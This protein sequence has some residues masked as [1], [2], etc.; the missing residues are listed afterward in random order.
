[1]AGGPEYEQVEKPT[2]EFLENLGYSFIDQPQNEDAREGLYNVILR[3][4]LIEA[5]QRI[6]KV[7][8]E[9]AE[10]TYS[11]LLSVRDHQRW[12]DILR[13]DYSRNVPGKSTQKTIRLIDFLNTDNNVFTLTNQFYVQSE[14]SRIPDLVVFVNGIPLVVIEAKKPVPTK[15]KMGE[16]FD[17]IKQ[18][19]QDIPRLFYSNTFNI[20]CDSHNLLFGAT[21]A[22]S[23]YWSTWRDPWP[24]KDE[25]F[26]N[27]RERGLYA[28]LEPSRLLD[29]LAHFIVFEKEDHKVTKKICRYQQFR[30]VNK[31]VNRVM[32]GKHQR[33]LIWHT[34]GSGKSLTMVFAALKLKKHLTVEHE[35]LTSP[36]LLV[37]TDRKALDKQ[38]AR[39]FRACG[40]PNP[41]RCASV[42]ELRKKL[43]Q[44]TLGLTLLST[45]H[46]FEGS[47]KS[48]ANAKDWIVLVDE[49]HR[50]QEKDLG[51]YLQATLDGARFFG[52]TGTPVKKTDRNTYKHFGAPGEGYLDR[53]SI[54]DSIADG[55]TVP[56][57]YTSRKAEFEVDEAKLDVLFDNWFKSVDE[58]KREEL[59]RKG[60]TL[61]TIAKVPE[62]IDLIAYDIWTHYLEHVKPDGFKAQVVAIDREAVILYKRALDKYITA[63][64]IREGKTP[65]EA[66][67]LADKFSTPVYSGNQEDGKPSEDPWVDGIRQDLRDNF[68]DEDDTDDAINDF[69]H[70]EYPKFLIVCSK[71]LTGFD[72]PIE[73]V[74]YLDQPLK[75]HNLLQA[76]ART[77]RPC[78]EHKQYG[79]IVDYIGVT[80]HLEEAL[81]SYHKADVEHALED[82]SGLR[83]KLRD[84][85]REVMK[86]IEGLEREK[87]TE[88][89]YQALAQ[90]LGSEDVWYTYRRKARWFIKTYEALSPDPYVLNFQK[91]LKWIAGSLVW[92]TVQFEKKDGVVDL[93]SYSAKIREMLERHLHVTGLRTLCEL[94][95]L[96][97]PKFWKDFDPNKSETDLKTAAIRKSAELKK[98]LAEKVSLNPLRYGPFSERVMELIKRLEAGQTTIAL[99]LKEMEQVAKDLEAEN[100]AH[101]GSGLDARAYGLFKILETFWQELGVVADGPADYE[102]MDGPITR[103]TK[104]IDE[105]YNSP[106][107]AP[108]GWH[109]K[110]QL[111]KSL[112]QQVRVKAN[113]AGFKG[114][115]LKAIPTRVEEYARKFYVKVI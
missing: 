65:D 47:K 28:L 84:A 73:H 33:G 51:A 70:E 58:E 10:A 88:A 4:T 107:S 79:L 77:N 80:R 87:G 71:L 82:Q 40:L 95:D 3:D 8:V 19:E 110:G 25:D 112:R 32:D 103:L 22:K 102:G 113:A 44:K 52:F 62:R 34:Q 21:H 86:M 94:R 85:H 13:G 2:I 74:M 81:A 111:Q 78:G 39:T 5:I 11:E 20:I 30:A 99:F 6:N 91:D 54:D 7:P 109:K 41:E 43:H 115:T 48:V 61:A 59:K 1:M 27:A 26:A 75:E 14:K 53:Y 24:K 83:D 97:D 23:S 98:I 45:I 55:A 90:A 114:K 15:S 100:N 101:E 67:K 37:L 42:A 38:I 36:N 69:V 63:E 56:V 49:C 31:M 104:E 50:T 66:A 64:L 9:V 46:K 72:A 92:C 108:A 89:E 16:A 96:S 12:L 18:Y 60:I 29:I 68:L 105:L 106:N 76:I 93:K 17:Q 57:K 35:A